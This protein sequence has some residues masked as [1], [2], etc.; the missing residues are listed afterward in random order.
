MKK[1]QRAKFDLT[2]VVSTAVDETREVT[3]RQSAEQQERSVS[4][5]VSKIMELGWDG[6][7][8]RYPLRPN[9][10]RASSTA[11]AQTA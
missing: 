3:I 4:W 2:G 10:R 9:R 7:F 5:V 1:E 6:Y 8:R 11:E